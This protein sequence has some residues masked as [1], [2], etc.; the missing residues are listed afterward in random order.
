MVLS[1]PR[2][3]RLMHLIVTVGNRYPILPLEATAVNNP[4]NSRSDIRA[5]AGATAGAT[6]E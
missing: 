6:A 5:T 3:G 2:A 1:L 4:G